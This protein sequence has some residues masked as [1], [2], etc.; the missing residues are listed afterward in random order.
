MES[1]RKG[2]K[3]V[4]VLGGSF[5]PITNA[6]L[7]IAAELIHSRSADEVWIIPCGPRPDKPSLST[8]VNHRIAMC[9]IAVASVFS[10]TFPVFVN[11]IEAA[12][13]AALSTFHLM[14]QLQKSHPDYSFHFVIGTDLISTLKTWDA[15]GVE[16]AGQLLWEKCNFLVLPRPGYEIPEKLPSNFRQIA[17]LPGLSIMSDNLSSS[18]IRARVRMQASLEKGNQNPDHLVESL[19]PLPVLSHLRRYKLYAIP[20]SI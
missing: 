14:E 16:N 3:K 8:P 2:P 15:P 20:R 19:I 9:H 10:A 5:D 4:A 18:E 13:P 7:K 1:E 17:A 11:E 6:H 12:L